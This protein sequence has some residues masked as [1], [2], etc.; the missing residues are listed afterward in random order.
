MNK[1]MTFGL[2]ILVSSMTLGG[3]TSNAFAQT[4][5]TILIT[6]ANRAQTQIERQI[7]DSSSDEIKQLFRNGIAEVKALEESL[8]QDDIET[9]KKHFLN[10][11]RIFAQ[12]SH[13]INEQENTQ[14]EATQLRAAPQPDYSSDLERIHKYVTSLKA[15]AKKYNAPI[16]FSE[17]DSLIDTAHKQARNG[18]SEIIH[19]INEIKHLVIEI[20]NDIRDFAAKQ[21][22]ERAKRY[23]Q[24][25]LE[26][27]DRLI[28][29]AKSQ[30]VSEEVIV[31]LETLKE[32]LSAANNPHDIVEKIKE[33]ISIKKQF[34]LTKN[35][36]IESRVIQI[37]KTIN[38]LSQIEG[39]DSEKIE[40]AKE[41]LALSKGYLR[42]GEFDKANELLREINEQ[43]R[44][45]ASSL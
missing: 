20:N 17:I 43:L 21:Q 44:A 34:E 1:I 38:R 24:Q 16:D 11:M 4:D 6:L 7:S 40:S 28:E 12:I 9:A 18:N 15:L 5:P 10:A 30:G 32:K 8:E 26:Q 35:D 42:E 36:R 25:Y 13:L 3:V 41:Q 31:K 22:Q 37:E 19:T 14:A 2:L 33:I 23:A 27:L 39:V 45:I 29:N